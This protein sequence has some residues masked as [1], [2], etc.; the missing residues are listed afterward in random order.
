MD[1]VTAVVLFAA[2]GAYAIIDLWSALRRSAAAS[3]TPK[4]RADAISIVAG[5]IVALLVMT[6][7]RLLFGP[8]VVA[9]GV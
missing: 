8:N 6:F 4:S 3:F 5:C 2:F 9:F 1:N 7:H